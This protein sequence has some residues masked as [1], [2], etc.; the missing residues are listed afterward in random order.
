MSSISLFINRHFRQIQEE[1]WLA[2]R[3]KAK[4]VVIRSINM[5]IA[6][7]AVLLVRL[8][9]PWFLIRFG[10]VRS[11]VIGH[12]VLDPEYYLCERELDKSK[13]IDYFYFASGKPPPNEQWT[14]MVRRHLRISSFYRF[15]DIVNRLIPGGE[16]HHKEAGTPGSKDLNGYFAKTKPHIKFISKEDDHG[17]QF[18][19]NLGMQTSDRFV[20]L[21]IRDSAY[22][23]K[24]QN[25]LLT[26]KARNNGLQ[27]LGEKYS[28]PFDE[29]E[30]AAKG[31]IHEMVFIKYLEKN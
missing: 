8:I 25:W 21:I 16:T 10:S 7:S 2:V 30:Q 28:L 19:E 13:T 12:S 1:G 26:V 17:R 23:E 24:Y 4:T 5:P 29:I 18:L 27:D 3:R 22:K 14:I 6:V 9:R 11:D 15:L 20:S 31:K